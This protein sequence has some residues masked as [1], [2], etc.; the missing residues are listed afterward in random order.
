[1]PIARGI[2]ICETNNRVTIIGRAPIANRTPISR[3]RRAVR[4]LTSP[5][6]PTAVSTSD[7]VAK[8]PRTSVW[9]L[10][11]RK[12]DVELIVELH[13]LIA[14]G[15]V[16]AKADTRRWRSLR[17]AGFLERS[18]A[19]TVTDRGVSPSVRYAAGCSA[20]PMR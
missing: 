7:S 10:G 9:N 8:E 1:M 11:V 17:V 5:Y 14:T 13:Q 3:F 15:E 16:G 20:L 18:F 12:A 2:I 19:I 4:K 6:T